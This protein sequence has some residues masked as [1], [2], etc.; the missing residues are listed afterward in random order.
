MLF[1]SFIFFIFLGVVLSAYRLISSRRGRV[2]FLLIASYFFYGYWDWRFTALLAISTVT[3][4]YV[5]LGLEHAERRGTR[6]WLLFL[7]C[8]INLG[9]LGLFKYFNFFIVNAKSA[10]SGLGISVGS[11]SL[12][13][14][15]PV[16]ISFYTFKTLSYSIDVYRR[17]LKPTHS[18]LDYALFVSF[19]PNLVAGPIERASKLLPQIENLK[20]PARQ[21]VKEGFVL[22]TLGLFKKVLIGDAAA[23]IVNNIFWQPELYRSPELLAAVILFSI[24]IYAD[25]AGYSNM[26]RGV[27][28][29]FGV[30]LM[31]NFEQPYFSRSFSEFWRRWHISLSTWI[32]DYIFNPLLSSFLR[33][34]GRWKLPSIQLEMRIAYPCAAMITMLL[35]GLWHG[36]G[37]TFIV[38]GGLHGLFLTVERL[39]V[40]RNKAIPM[41]TRIRNPKSFL[42]FVIRL[43]STQ[44]FVI[45]AWLFFRVKDIDQAFY[46]LG[47]FI[48]WQSSELTGRLIVIVVSFS[49]MVALLDLIEYISKSEV[50]LV[51][52]KPVVT[53][54]IC[55]AVIF[56]VFL[57]MATTKPLPFVYFQF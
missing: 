6:K 15:L 16:G 27:A 20:T 3:D 4:F 55:L 47:R 48:H 52:L 2:F 46:F 38:W 18:F 26:A 12:N 25:F 43:A 21:Q 51:R 39:A 50:Y 35:C 36:A 22:I 23:R 45:F 31:K 19:F 42:R 17:K 8:F 14:V 37:F 11:L 10:L 13:I 32:W 34:L 56:I 49:L 9:I 1:N 29:L 30:E 28:K 44:F 33:R 5:G 41:R 7:S 24:Q 53:A 57:Y 40:Y 54:G